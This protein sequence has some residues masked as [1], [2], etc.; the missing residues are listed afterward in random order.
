MANG[1]EPGQPGQPWARSLP[2]LTHLS[3]VPLA[4]VALAA[5]AKLN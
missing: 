3:P 5:S 4:A 2:L 1:S